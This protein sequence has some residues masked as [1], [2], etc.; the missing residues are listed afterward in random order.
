MWI[1]EGADFFRKNRRAAKSAAKRALSA[2]LSNCDTSTTAEMR[3]STMRSAMSLPPVGSRGTS[4]RSPPHT[5]RVD[6]HEL[7]AGV[8]EELGELHRGVRLAA[9]GAPEE[10]KLLG[11]DR[12]GEVE[13]VA[14]AEVLHVRALAGNWRMRRYVGHSDQSPPFR[15]RSIPL[16]SRTLAPS[17]FTKQ[18]TPA[19][20]QPSTTSRAHVGLKWRAFGPLSPP[21]MIQSSAGVSSSF[22]RQRGVTTKMG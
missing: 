11:R 2:S 7:R 1:A 12:R 5:D 3:R 17:C 21:T 14:D 16:K 13:R 10:G 19:A 8:V 18:A 9:A 4:P 6:G 22:R 20:R 15:S